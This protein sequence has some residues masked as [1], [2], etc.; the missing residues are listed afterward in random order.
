MNHNSFS[1]Q[2]PSLCFILSAHS[3]N[4][5]MDSEVNFSTVRPT[6]DVIVVGAG[7]AGLTA[8]YRLQQQQ[9][10]CRVLVLDAK[11]IHH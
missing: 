5:T 7:I 8:A 9:P 11:G 4:F 3:L 1:L 6:L 2:K 10:N